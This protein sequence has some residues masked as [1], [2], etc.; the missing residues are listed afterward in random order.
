MG[1]KTER[2]R[3]EI[4]NHFQ[5]SDLNDNE[6]AIVNV[7]GKGAKNEVIHIVDAESKKHTIHLKQGNDTSYKLKK[8]GVAYTVTTNKYGGDE[9][10]TNFYTNKKTD[11]D[12]QV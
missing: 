7:F 1:S 2:K 9:R 11:R 4:A 12:K 8:N 5:D 3:N 10:F 6:R